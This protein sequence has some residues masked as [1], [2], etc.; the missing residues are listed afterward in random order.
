MNKKREKKQ[1]I[2]KETMSRLLQGHSTVRQLFTATG[3]TS[4]SHTHR[5]RVVIRDTL[6]LLQD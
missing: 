3:H 4:S 2:L 6:Y 1:C 5:E